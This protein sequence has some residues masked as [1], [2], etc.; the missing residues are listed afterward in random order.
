MQQII[1]FFIR[2]KNFLLFLLLFTISIAFTINSHTYH[3]NRFVSSANFISG[4]IFGFKSAI[5][6]YLG[7]KSQNEKLAKENRE[8][9]S[10]LLNVNPSGEVENT[11]PPL[12]VDST[13]TFINAKVINNS[14]G[15]T[16]NQLT[17]DKGKK[18]G[19]VIDMGVMS[20]EGVVGI[21][22]HTSSNYASVQSV[23]NTNSQ[24]VAKF[25]KSNHFG[26]LVWD[27]KDPSILQLKEIP[28]IAPVGK[29][30]TIV[31]DGRSTIFPEGI[32]IGT[33]SD[34]EIEEVGDYYRI[35]VKLLTDMTSLKHVYLVQRVDAPEIKALENEANDVE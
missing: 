21:V 26:T 28:R 15:R 19:V 30:D 13:Y 12:V 14:Y 32:P 5:T 1:H 8:L 27:G 18:D 25:K 10:R 16:K 17:I 23:L 33:V 35:Q 29:G 9:R 3:G 34:F 2:N 11:N 20:P 6:E 4:S 7:L 31:T 22:S 24:V